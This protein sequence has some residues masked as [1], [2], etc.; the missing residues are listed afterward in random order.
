MKKCCV[1]IL[2]LFLCAGIAQAQIERGDTEVSFL[3]F[4]SMFVGENVD[5]NGSGSLQLSYGKYISSYLQIGIAP[6]FCCFEIYPLSQ[7]TVLSVHF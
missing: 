3:G 4:F 5:A 1:P 2:A 7:R 6:I